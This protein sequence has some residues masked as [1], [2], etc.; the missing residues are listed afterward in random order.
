MDE[1]KTDSVRLGE[2]F[3]TI[4][5]QGLG[6]YATEQGPEKVLS[7]QLNKRPFSFEEMT[8]PKPVNKVWLKATPEIPTYTNLRPFTRTVRTRSKEAMVRKK[9]LKKKI[10]KH[11]S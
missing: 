8:P 9:D 5:R 1:D 2:R 11:H 7:I 4:E 6:P 3:W 10:Y